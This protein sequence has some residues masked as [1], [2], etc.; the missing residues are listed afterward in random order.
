MTRP[1]VDILLPFHGQ[2]ESVTK[3]IGSIFSCTPNQDYNIILID[4]ASPNPH[5]V[6]ALSEHRKK[7]FG[8]RLNEQVGFGGALAEGFRISQNPLVA[9]VHSDV[10]MENI[11]WLANL[12]RALV[13]LKPQGVKLVSSRSDNPGTSCSYDSRMFGLPE[14][15]IGDVITDI[16]GPLICSLCHRDLFARIGFIKPYPYAWY[17]D[18]E[19]F[20]RMKRHGFKQA[21]VSN[22]YVRHTGGLTINELCRTKPKVI[23]IMEYNR[24]LC[25]ADISSQRRG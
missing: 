2:Y 10:W 15:N 6:K 9:I 11:N 5:Y 25:L 1:S 16:P 14:D 21:I 8:I 20:W 7:V 3:C 22:S 24:E 19:L 12:Q 4:D 13:R 17:E 23:P 18:E